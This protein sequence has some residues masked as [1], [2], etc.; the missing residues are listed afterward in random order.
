MQRAQPDSSIPSHT[1]FLFLMSGNSITY[2]GMAPHSLPAWDFGSPHSRNFLPHIPS[3]VPFCSKPPAAASRLLPS[4]AGHTTTP[5]VTPPLLIG[6]A[7]VA[8]AAGHTAS[9]LASTA[10]RPRPRVPGYVRRLHSSLGGAAATTLPLFHRRGHRRAQGLRYAIFCIYHSTAPVEGPNNGGKDHGLIRYTSSSMSVLLLFGARSTICFFDVV[11]R[12][13]LLCKV[14][15]SLNES[16][17][18]IHTHG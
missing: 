9:T 18:Q 1:F 14:L 7:A 11:L 4:L 2:V 12:C 17:N 16:L 5:M 6:A 13:S 3:S 10:S 8:T 15:P